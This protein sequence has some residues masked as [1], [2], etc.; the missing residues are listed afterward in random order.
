VRGGALVPFGLAALVGVLAA[1]LLAA[2]LLAPA[3][4]PARAATAPA[5]VRDRARLTGPL[6]A[7]VAA[8]AKRP[9]TAGLTAALAPL[10]RDKT[11]GGRVSVSVRDL[12][13]GKQLYGRAPTTGFTP[14]STTKLLTTAAVLSLLGP[15]H[16]FTT[17]VVLDP[18]P[19]PTTKTPAPSP[20]TIVLVGGGDPLLSSQAA[21]TRATKRGHVVYPDATTATIDELATRTAAA[22][23]A[24]GHTRVALRYDASLFSQPLSPHW[25][26]VYV[27]SS[28]VA[29]VS[30]LWVDEARIKAP[31][32]TRVADPAKD[33]AARFAVLLAK[34]GITVSGAPTPQRAVRGATT[35]SSIESAP[36]DSIV[37]HV[38]LTSD[39]DGAEVLARQVA[40]AAGARPDFAGA[41]SAVLARLQS[42]G[43]NTAGVRLYDGSGLSRDG[44]IPASTLTALIDVIAAG[45][46]PELVGRAV[47]AAGG[48]IRRSAR[49]PVP[50]RRRERGR[51]RASEDRHAHRAGVAR[52]HGDDPGR[53]AAL[54]R[55][56]DRPDRR[57]RCPARRGPDRRHHRRVRLPVRFGLTGCSLG[58]EHERL[59]GT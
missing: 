56:D 33:A 17:R 22:L 52:R 41:T 18:V 32:S 3:T 37:E 15:D 58:S 14:A 6:L 25:R 51:V 36:L 27:D 29:P 46:H 35:V 10:L 23:T 55:G 43:V 7:P 13:T 54:V 42:L 21:L 30:A 9:T 34:R 53:R 49:Q 45:R 19:K 50:R 4:A 12:V 39:N 38:L 47:R 31:F 48:W 24:D 8:D 1:G 11:L 2:G 5:P 20:P 59:A 57:D 16:R 40:L 44:R 28:V 26:E